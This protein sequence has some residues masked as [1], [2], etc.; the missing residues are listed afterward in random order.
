MPTGPTQSATLPQSKQG[1]IDGALIFLEDATLAAD[2]STA[3]IDVG[4]TVLLS[5][6]MLEGT[7]SSDSVRFTVQPAD[8]TTGT[9]TEDGESLQVASAGVGRFAVSFS[10]QSQSGA[11]KRAIRLAYDLG[12]T[13]PVAG[14][15]AYVAKGL[16][17]GT[18]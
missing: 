5:T 11:V 18:S 10:N 17:D 16:N 3:W 8:D 9:N 14:K 1:T 13:G 4:P 12:A 2:G 15:I 6:A 7:A